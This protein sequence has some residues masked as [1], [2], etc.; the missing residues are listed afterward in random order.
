MERKDADI[1]HSKTNKEKIIEH[2]YTNQE[3][4]DT[5]KRPNLR[6]MG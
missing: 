3:V 2:D 5:V 6:S 4:W 1:L